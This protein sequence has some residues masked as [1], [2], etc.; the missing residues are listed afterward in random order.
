[1]IIIVDSDGLIG[2]LD[3]ND[4]HFLSTQSILQ[5]LT[6]KEA[7]FIYPATVITE[8]TAVLKLRLQRPELAEKIM[9]LLLEGGLIIEPVDEDALKKAAILLNGKGNKHQTLFDGVVAA[10]AN[11]YSADAIFSFDK[12]YKTKGF[13]LASE[14]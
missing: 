10:I 9:K 11:K 3:K 1:M 14:L 7:K 13:K 8:S 5:K 12:F 6:H 2:L 4:A